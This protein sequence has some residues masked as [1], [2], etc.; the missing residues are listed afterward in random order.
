MKLNWNCFDDVL[1]KLEELQELIPSCDND[2]WVD[3]QAFSI[4]EIAHY[5]PQYNWMDVFYATY[6]LYRAGYVHGKFDSIDCSI[7]GFVSG[8]TYKGH[9]KLQNDRLTGKYEDG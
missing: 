2:E 9:L 3:F 4:E 5:L 8:I 1:K 6:N 7:H